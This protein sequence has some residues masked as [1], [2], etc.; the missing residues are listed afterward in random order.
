MEREFLWGGDWD[1]PKSAEAR[2]APALGLIRRVPHDG[3][4]G[5]AWRGALDGDGFGQPAT[6]SH[7]RPVMRCCSKR[8]ARLD[9]RPERHKTLCASGGILSKIL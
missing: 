5:L 2:G 3:P 9:R 4:V 7:F 6:T 8:I 1:R